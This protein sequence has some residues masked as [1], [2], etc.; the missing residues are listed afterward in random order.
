MAELVE[1]KTCTNKGDPNEKTCPNCGGAL[2]LIKTGIE[3]IIETMTPVKLAKWLLWVGGVA[4]IG[5]LLV[6]AFYWG[7]FGDLSS[8]Q[9]DWGEFGSYFG[10]TLSPIL[11]FI[12]LM[13]LL[14]TIVLQSKELELTREELRRSADAQAATKNILNEQSK[15]LAR[16]QFES[17]FFSLLDHHNK[18]LEHISTIHTG[19]TSSYLSYVNGYV[20]LESDPTNLDLAKAALE[21]KNDFCGHYFMVLYQLLKF[22]ATNVPGGSIGQEFEADKIQFQDLTDNEKMYSNIVRSCLYY[23]VTQL[24]SIN[25][26]CTGPEDTYWRYKLLIERYAFLEHMPFELHF[27]EQKVLVETTEFYKP[28]A[29]GNSGFLKKLKS[30]NAI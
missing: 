25:C 24:L 10:G 16:Q 1:C 13:A 5:M 22:I 3:Q 9:K 23:S 6:L 12:S 18:A 17:T 7:H 30:S 29:F 8:K 28:S 19:Q 2:T 4:F 26:Y 14:S 20:F 11:S 21:K 15:T 27:T